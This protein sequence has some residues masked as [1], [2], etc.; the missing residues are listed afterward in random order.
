[1]VADAFIGP[2]P[3]GAVIRHLN[4]KANDNRPENLAYGTQAENVQDEVRHGTHVEARKTTCPKG[5][6]Y[7]AMNGVGRRC[8]QCHRENERKRLGYAGISPKFRNH[9]VHGH[10]YTPENTYIAPHNSQRV[11]RECKRIESR[12]KRAKAKLHRS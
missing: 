6:P 4:G 1:M 3:N 11:C 7:D 9:C 8:R 10:E 5:H 12:R 2:R